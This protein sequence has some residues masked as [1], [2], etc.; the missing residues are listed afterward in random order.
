MADRGLTADT[1]RIASNNGTFSF[2]YGGSSTPVWS[3]TATGDLASS[4]LYVQVMQT[5]GD[6]AVGTYRVTNF[7]YHNTALGVYPTTGTLGSTIYDSGKTGTNWL[8]AT[9]V[10]P[11]GSGNLTGVSG[12]YLQ[13]RA[14]LTSNGT[15]TPTLGN[16]QISA[17]GDNASFL[18]VTSY[19]A[20]GNRTLKT[21]TTDAGTTTESYLVNNL[22]QIQTALGGVIWTY[23]WDEDSRLTRVQ[24]PGVDVSYEYDI[25]GRMLTR[26]SG[27]ITTRFL[28]DGW[29][30]IRE[31]TGSSVTR[32]F[33][34]QGQPQNIHDRTF[35]DQ[36]NCKKG[37]VTARSTARGGV[38]CLLQRGGELPVAL[39]KADPMFRFGLAG[40]LLLHLHQLDLHTVQPSEHGSDNGVSCLVGPEDLNAV[41]FQGIGGIA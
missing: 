18:T 34:P 16:V 39:V 26:T 41:R 21:T 11:D 24:G 25:L 23:T 31:T 38:F 37:G 13:Y 12:R 5:M 9:Y 14:T 20:T 6:Y 33:A 7:Q 8:K 35:G 36:S 1:L 40:L 22:N 32:Y 29:T 4:P 30:C 3:G 15:A 17:A 28:W 2:Y 27:S 19:D 10:S